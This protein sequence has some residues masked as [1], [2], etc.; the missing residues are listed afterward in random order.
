M[1]EIL[2]SVKL[3]R[4]LSS[5]PLTLNIIVIDVVV[6]INFIRNDNIVCALT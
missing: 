4:A 5:P 2:V 1:N 3:I 6:A